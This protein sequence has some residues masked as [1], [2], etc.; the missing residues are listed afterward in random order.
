M[1]PARSSASHASVAYLRIPD[2][3][4]HGVAEGAARAT[5]RGEVMATREFRD[6][7]TRSRPGM[8]RLLARSG[9]AVDDQGRALEIFRADRHTVAKRRRTFFAVAVLIAVGL[10][11][12][13]TVI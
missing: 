10:V 4:Q 5:S 1:S 8:R 11:F 9:T 12:A 13:A 2:F 7:L 3:A 6:A